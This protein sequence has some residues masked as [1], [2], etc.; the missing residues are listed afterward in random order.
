MFK[1][2]G[3]SVPSLKMSRLS[4]CQTLACH[5]LGCSQG[6]RLKCSATGNPPPL[7]WAFCLK[8]PTE[9]RLSDRFREHLRP[10][11]GFK[12]KPPTREV[13]STSLNTSIS[14][15]TTKSMA[16]ECLWWGKWKEERWHDNHESDGRILDIVHSLIN[17]QQLGLTSSKTAL[18]LWELYKLC[19]ATILQN[20]LH[21][22]NV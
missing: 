4:L 18:Y 12:Q 22:F 10:E 5:G 1:P 21:M 3:A 6:S 11:E 13:G 14:L 17:T 8:P 16:F 20:K 19:F 7:K 2:P 9:R 15:N